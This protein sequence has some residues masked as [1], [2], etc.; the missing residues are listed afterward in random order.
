VPDDE[1]DGY[2]VDDC[3]S[4]PYEGY[5][6]DCEDDA[7]LELYLEDRWLERRDALGRPAVKLQPVVVSRPL[8]HA[9]GRAPRRIRRTVRRLT[10]ARPSEPPPPARTV[11]RGKRWVR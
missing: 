8:R 9:R 1:L 11:R 5:G 7:R 3:P 2:D 10:P 6:Q 4:E